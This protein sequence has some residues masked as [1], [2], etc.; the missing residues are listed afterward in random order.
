MT[1]LR[2]QAGMNERTCAIKDCGR[3]I[4]ARGWCGRHYQQWLQHGDPLHVPYAGSVPCLGCGG[5]IRARNSYG[6][7]H[8]NPGCAVEY[9]RR[10]LAAHR[11]S[12]H[13][14]RRRNR[15]A[16]LEA[17]REAERRKYAATAASMNA[18]AARWRQAN[19]EKNR[20][21]Q[22][23][24]RSANRDKVRAA[25]ARRL[26]RAD[27]PCRRRPCAD[28]AAVG[29]EYCPLHDSEAAARRYARRARRLERE[30]Y[31]RQ[32]G[33]CPDLGHGGC[34]LPLGQATGHH[35]DHLIPLAS[36][37][38]DED[39]NLQLLHRDCNIR[40]AA[41]LVP[42]ALELIRLRNCQAITH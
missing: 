15:L 5:P 30:L 26:A 8:N 11:D 16:N 42:A 21:S 14:R 25:R 2:E 22:A 24:W 7:C 28:F 34:G 35:V 9:K 19:P 1:N 40:K 38:A 23:R 31:E 12:E 36:K 13:E 10:W 27:R 6:Y 4:L 17:A 3:P 39:W 32:D 41:K 18:A 29:R 37:G 33:L 20:A